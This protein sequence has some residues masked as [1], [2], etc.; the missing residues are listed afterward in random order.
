V[1]AEGVLGARAIIEDGSRRSVGFGCC[2]LGFI[3]LMSEEYKAS[4]LKRD[5]F[6]EK[7]VRV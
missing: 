4:M 2:M 5:V 7:V 1:K 6:F 3:I